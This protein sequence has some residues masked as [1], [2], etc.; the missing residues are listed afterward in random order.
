MAMIGLLI[1]IVPVYLL[2]DVFFEI[3]V[4]PGYRVG[5]CSQYSIYIYREIIIN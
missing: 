1:V 5:E 3:V 2:L 4:F